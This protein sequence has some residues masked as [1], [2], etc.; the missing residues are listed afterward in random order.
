MATEIYQ[1][2]SESPR[3]ADGRPIDEKKDGLVQADATSDLEGNSD[4]ESKRIALDRAEAT[5]LTPVEA[6]KWNVE[7][8]QSPCEC[9]AE[10]QKSN[11]GRRR[12]D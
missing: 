7:G 3:A 10:N 11:P 6:F 1:V 2:G 4:E 12:R 9:S 5:E 8:D